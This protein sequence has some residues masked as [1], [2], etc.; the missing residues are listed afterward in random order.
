MFTN[1]RVTAIKFSVQTQ[2][3]RDMSSSSNEDMKR[4]QINL[5]E[6]RKQLCQYSD[7][8]SEVKAQKSLSAF[9]LLS[10]REENS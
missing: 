6:P 8:V 2:F 5:S 9:D 3:K 1:K 10:F 4:K 7:P